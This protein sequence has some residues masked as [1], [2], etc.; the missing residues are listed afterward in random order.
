MCYY[1]EE[2]TKNKLRF[3][4][5]KHYKRYEFD[6]KKFINKIMFDDIIQDNENLEK[7]CKVLSTFKLNKEVNVSENIGEWQYVSF[8]ENTK[9]PFEPLNKKIE[10]KYLHFNGTYKIYK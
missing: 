9:S 6:N 10:C 1:I 5:I 3:K 2:I 7:L 4:V 8:D